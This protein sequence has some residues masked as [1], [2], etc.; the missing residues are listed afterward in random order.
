[1]GA[2]A[3]APVDD[4]APA[5]PAAASSDLEVVELAAGFGG[6]AVFRR[7]GFRV[8]RGES[9]AIIGPNGA[10]KSTLLRSIIR[11]IE[12]TEG[13]VR[14]VGQEVRM[15]RERE[16]RRLR[17]RIGFVFQRH[18]LVARLS[19]LTNVVHGAQARTDGPRT[20]LQS[21]APPALRD[22]A[23]DCLSRVGLAHVAGRRADR[24]SGGQSQRV[25]IAR[26]LM[27]RPQLVLADEPVA[28]LDPSAGEEV[29]SLF[30]G[31][32]RT[33]GLT[34]VFTTHNLHHARAYADRIIG[35]AGGSLAFDLPAGAAGEGQL[36]RLFGA[37]DG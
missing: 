22:E 21:L 14:L 13:A 23:M 20:W 33:S 29:M 16:L 10:G 35:L 12:P 37:R 24:L 34:V 1:M 4:A 18:N 36:A 9:V 25:A 11:L 17:S 2:S 26:M 3:L 15:L 5:E 31:L 28:S 8:A 19:A 6:H 32:M 27:Q 30:A 7:V